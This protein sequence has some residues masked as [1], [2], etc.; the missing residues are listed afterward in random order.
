MKTK[1]F[2]TGIDTEVGKTYVSTGLLHAAARRQLRCFGLKPIASGATLQDGELKNEDALALQSASTLQLPYRQINP[3][4]FEPAIAPHIAAMQKGQLI[5]A[6][7]VEGM[8]NGTSLLSYDF[9]LVEGAGGWRVPLNDREYFSDI[10]KRLQW[11]VVLVVSM[12]LGCINHALLS[13]QAIL[14]DG[15]KLAGWVANTGAE[16]MPFYDENLATLKV[17]MSAPCLGTISWQ[18]DQSTYDDE[19]DQIFANLVESIHPTAGA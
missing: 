3:F 11:P 7:R 1:I 16:R 6:S 8:I 10:A 12:R 19:F 17:A 5:T 4:V 14:S 9:C 18:A 13:A 2:V 15:L